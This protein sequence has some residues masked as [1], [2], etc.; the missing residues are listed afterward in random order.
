MTVVPPNADENSEIDEIVSA[1]LDGE[2]APD[3]QARVESDPA[4]LT[5]V[6]QLRA[7]S[8]TVAAPASASP[9]L[10]ELH[11]SAALDLFD[12]QHELSTPTK[13]ESQAK[14]PEPAPVASLDSARERKRPRRLNFVTGIA[15][16]LAL[17]FAGIVAFGWN[18]GT[19]DEVVSDD[20]AI[21]AMAQDASD[22]PEAP[23]SGAASDAAANSAGSTSASSAEASNPAS[24]N[25]ASSD[26]ASSDATNDAGDDDEAMADDEA[27]A[28][29]ASGIASSAAVPPGSISVREP[30]ADAEARFADD[31]FDA[32]SAFTAEPLFIGAFDDIASAQAGFAVSVHG[33]RLPEPAN[34]PEVIQ[35]ETFAPLDCSYQ[36]SLPTNLGAGTLLATG[37]VDGAA[38]EF[39]RTDS[40]VVLI[41]DHQSCTE[42]GTFARP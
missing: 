33:S 37:T 10:K 20:V 18:S 27:S 29:D 13:G 4:L 30:E 6:E 41:V 22:A 40:D 5:R 28:A 31:D 17:V 7:Q 23:A 36:L 3:E 35:R 26:A 2:A 39:H 25:A 42:L 12:S 34:S 14:S 8:L 21:E 1:Y 9:A 16:A 15:A 38:I 19:G 11:L 32:L 24:S